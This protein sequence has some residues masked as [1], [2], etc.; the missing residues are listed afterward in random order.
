[1]STVLSAIAAA[2]YLA[3]SIRYQRSLYAS[4]E[5][6]VN[7]PLQGR[8]FVMLAFALQIAAVFQA[9]RETGACPLTLAQ[10][11]NLICCTMVGLYLV[12]ST[13]WKMDV[14]GAFAAPAATLVMMGSLGTAHLY[15]STEALHDPLLALHVACIILGYAA[16]L[17]ASIVAA[18]Y[19]FQTLLLK[20]KAVTGMLMKMPSLDNLDRVT[21]LLIAIGFLPMGAGIGLGF[22]RA[23]AQG[24]RFWSFDVVLGLL[25]LLIYAIYIHARLLGGWQ[26][27]KVN[28]LLLVGFVFLIA[29]YVGIGIPS[30][31]HGPR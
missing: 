26:G 23:E 3:A 13:V 21:Y 28:G 16:F 22:L 25:T 2:L 18:L 27:R 5:A 11:L 29:T 19:F 8:G 31:V 14:V 24:L 12:V 6:G 9:G 30:G 1:M 20:R 10:S 15:G 7:S 4:A 17:L